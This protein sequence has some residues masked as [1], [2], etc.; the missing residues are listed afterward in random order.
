MDPISLITV[1]GAAGVAV[2]VL[3]LITDGRLHSSS[4]VDGLRQDIVDLKKVNTTLSNALKS[5]NEL[6][7]EILK[8]LRERGRHDN[9]E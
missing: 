3:K 2:W 6:L 8:L 7:P 5:S 4:E 1:G 9:P